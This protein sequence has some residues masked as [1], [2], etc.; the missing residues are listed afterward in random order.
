MAGVHNDLNV[1]IINNDRAEDISSN[2]NNMN[3]VQHRKTSKRNSETVLSHI[4]MHII[5]KILNAV[6]LKL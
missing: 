6:L 2:V 5:H 4:S 1:V 3:H